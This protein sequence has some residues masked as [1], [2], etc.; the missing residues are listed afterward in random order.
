VSGSAINSNRDLADRLD[1]FD[2]Q[3]VECSPRLMIELQGLMGLAAEA[4]RQSRPVPSG[5]MVVPVNPTI[6]MHNA[7]ALAGIYEAPRISMNEDGYVR[8]LHACPDWSRVWRSMIEASPRQPESS[9][10]EERR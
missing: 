4:L 9:A 8:V 7:A 10:T 3:D 6:S 2:F 1:A 5:W